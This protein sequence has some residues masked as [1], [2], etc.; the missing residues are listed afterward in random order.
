MDACMHAWMDRWA[1][2]RWGSQEAVP[3]KGAFIWGELRASLVQAL[4]GLHGSSP[5]VLPALGL[6]HLHCGLVL[7]LL[8][9][10]FKQCQIFLG[11]R[12]QEEAE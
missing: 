10:L 1:G 3:T 11:A 4:E 5:A 12:Q 2:G 9:L 8:Q 6:V 7:D